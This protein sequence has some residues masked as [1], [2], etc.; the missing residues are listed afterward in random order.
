MSLSVDW[1][2]LL[3]TVLLA[4]LLLALLAQAL[5][6]LLALFAL[7]LFA[8]LFAP[9][10]LVQTLRLANL[11]PMAEQ[12]SLFPLKASL[13]APLTAP[14]KALPKVPPKVPPQTPQA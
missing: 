8:Q 9:R 6:A 12:A 4:H 2:R 13:K 7:A 1:P 3:L 10:A 14:P 5:F 11:A